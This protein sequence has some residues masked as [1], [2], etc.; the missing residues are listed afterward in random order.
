MKF[1][2]AFCNKGNHWIDFLEV[3]L[4]DDFLQRIV[5]TRHI[6][7]SN[8]LKTVSLEPP[9]DF[10]KKGFNPDDKIRSLS[11][12]ILSN[13][14]VLKVEGINRHEYAEYRLLK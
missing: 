2:K 14:V 10:L 3:N 9:C 12:Y 6:L 5:N 11:L 1:S 7:K 13:E 8:N 4:S